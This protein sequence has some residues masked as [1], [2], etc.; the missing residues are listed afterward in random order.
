MKLLLSEEKRMHGRWLNRLNS[1]PD[2]D[3]YCR[4]QRRVLQRCI[5]DLENMIFEQESRSL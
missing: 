5:N 4:V 2:T 1:M 3:E